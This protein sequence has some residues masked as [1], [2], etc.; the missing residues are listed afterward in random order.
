[1][2]ARYDLAVEAIKTFHTGV[3]EDFLLKQEQFKELRDRL[4]KS[5]SD[6]YGK[7]RRLLGKETD[8]ASRRCLLQVEL[9]AGRP[10]RQGRPQPRTRWRRTGRCW[11]RGRRWRPSRGPAP[12][13]KVDVG[14]SLTAVAG[15]LEATGRTGEAVATYRRSE[16]LL[17]GLA[18]ADPAARAALAA[19][20]SRLGIAPVEHG[21]GRQRAGGLPAGA[22]RPGGPAA[23]PGASADARRDLA[24]TVNGIGF[25]LSN[26]L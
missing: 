16:S 7:L 8:L 24:D 17:A 15:L 22:G 26:G 21:P 18:A 2:Q 23:A 11:R 6:F 19:C 5:A 1:M 20:R 9:R 25:L 3:S 4:L 10:D 13:A 14:R 12:A